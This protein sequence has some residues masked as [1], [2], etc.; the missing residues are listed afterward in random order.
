[1]LE[2]VA[3]IAHGAVQAPGPLPAP[4]PCAGP[5]HADDVEPVWEVCNCSS[6]ARHSDGPAASGRALTCA[7]HPRAEYLVRWRRSAHASHHVASHTLFPKQHHAK[8]KPAALACYELLAVRKKKK[9]KKKKK[10]LS[11]IKI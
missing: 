8:W 7:C 9:K 10:L 1:M 11:L 2:D 3:A 6:G 4:P 5:A